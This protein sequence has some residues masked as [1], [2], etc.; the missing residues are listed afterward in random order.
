MAFDILVQK[1]YQNIYSYCV[2]RIG[3]DAAADLTQEVFLKLVKT[4]YAY[5]FTG[6]FTSFLF[7]IAVNTCNDYAKKPH[8][9]CEDIDC[10]Q[11]SDGHPAPLEKVLDSEQAE[12]IRHELDALSDTQKDAIILY[13]YHGLKAKDIAKITGVGVPT[14]KSRLK[15]GM[16]KLKKSFQKEDYFEKQ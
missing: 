14:A 4:I 9:S 1:H 12:M 2:R 6:K 11:E 7:T 5:R 10:L 15:Q 16:D 3:Y 8:R 13:Y